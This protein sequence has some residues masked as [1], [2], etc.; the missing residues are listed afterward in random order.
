MQTR[1]IRVCIRASLIKIGEVSS[2]TRLFSA[3]FLLT[4]S[5]IGSGRVILRTL[6]IDIVY[7]GTIPN[8]EKHGTNEED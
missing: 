7:D 1:R 2:A 4:D 5:A 8:E 3:V 6:S